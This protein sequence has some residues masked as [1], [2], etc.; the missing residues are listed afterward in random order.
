MDASANDPSFN[1]TNSNHPHDTEEYE[2]IRG[3]VLVGGIVQAFLLGFIIGQAIKYFTHYPDDSWRKRLFVGTVVVLSV[4]QTIIEEFKVWKVAIDFQPWAKSAFAWTDILIN[5]FI[6]WMCEAFFVRRC[7]KAT[8]RNRWVLGIL[9]FLSSTILLVNVYLTVNLALIVTQFDRETEVIKG[10]HFLMPS[11]RIAFTY[12]ISA[13]LA[14]DVIVAAILIFNLWHSKTGQKSSDQVVNSVIWIT[15]ISTAMPCISM[16]CAVSVYHS[17]KE[18]N[19]VL[20]FVLL[21]SKFYTF[22]LLRTL[23]ARGNLRLRMKSHDLG[24]VTLSAW[25]WDQ[26]QNQGATVVAETPELP[27]PNTVDKGFSFRTAFGPISYQ[28]SSSTTTATSSRSYLTRLDEEI[29]P[30]QVS[31]HASV[32]SAMSPEMPFSSPRLDSFERGYPM[33]RISSMTNKYPHQSKF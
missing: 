25:Q 3:S 10:A 2:Q 29:P 12:W 15:C 1:S 4:L 30:H 24:R 11:I 16:V 14:L 17:K 28:P 22:G 8:N 27:S 19:L 31:V 20:L 6:S 18:S 7:W 23:N 13:S 33:R 9:G 21:T 26:A 5:G 32:V